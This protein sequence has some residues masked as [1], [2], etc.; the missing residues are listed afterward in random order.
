MSNPANVYR[1][2]V[3]EL[4][5]LRRDPVMLVLI[6]YSFTLGIY[7]AATAVPETL[8]NA[9]IAIVDEDNS[10]L[11]G[12]IGMAF[13]PPHFNWPM[14]IPW[15]QVDPGMDAGRFTFA[16]NIPPNFQRACRS[17]PGHP[18]QRGCDANEPGVHRQRLYP[19]H[20]DG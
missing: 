9:P 6:G 16:L 12:R 10:P 8:H 5:S 20:R 14:M 1:L 11:S 4:W 18:T 17:F 19:E 15:T 3:K 13:F 2:G 7:S